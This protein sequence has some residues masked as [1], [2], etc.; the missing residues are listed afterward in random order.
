[1]KSIQT[2]LIK[3]L[4]ILFTFITCIA[5]CKQSSGYIFY[6]IPVTDVKVEGYLGDQIEKTI[7]N[8][9]LKI[10]VDSVFLCHYANRNDKPG[11]RD[12]YCGFGEYIDAV[13]RLAAYSHDTTLIRLKDRLIKSL[14][15]TQ[16]SDGYIGIFQNKDKREHTWDCQDRFFNIIALV[17][18]YNFYKHDSS[19]HAAEKLANYSMTHKNQ[20]VTT[21][22]EALLMLFKATKNSKYLNYVIDS[23]GLKEFRNGTPHNST[24]V[25]GILDRDYAQLKLYEFMR[26]RTLLYKSIS[27][28]QGMLTLSGMDQVGTAGVWEHWWPVHEGKW[29]NGETCA[30]VYSIKMLNELL[31]IEGKTYYG[32][33]LERVMYNAL[34]AAQSPDGRKLRYFTTFQDTRTYYPDDYFCCPGNYRRAI[35]DIPEQIYYRTDRGIAINLYNESQ[36]KIKVGRDTVLISQKTDYPSEGTVKIAISSPNK[37]KF[38]V[39]LRIPLW[40]KDFTLRINRDTI[41]SG[42][43]GEFCTITRKWSYNDTIFLNLEM[44]WRFIKGRQ[45]QGSRVAVTRGPLF[46]CLSYDKNKNLINNSVNNIVINPSTISKP[47]PTNSLR[48]NGRYANVTIVSVNDSLKNTEGILTE[49]IDPSC[50]RTFFSISDSMYNRYSKSDELFTNDWKINMIPK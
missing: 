38:D 9:I 41:N 1:M 14:I 12:D 4:L 50:I 43:P 8:N 40:C 19:L 30:S 25:Y 28:L 32:D 5:S 34:F 44:P 26:N 10:N 21:M 47:I 45:A 16:D 35:S 48:K 39:M 18:N 31:K 37:R 33:I 27:T 46:F 6:S 13:V 17:E 42:I 22:E 3:K 29:Q 2:V 49:F 36:A 24:H 7:H 15:K 23:T 20:E 11:L